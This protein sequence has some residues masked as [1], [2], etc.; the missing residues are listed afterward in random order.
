MLWKPLFALS[1]L[2]AASAVLAA[3]EPA[4]AAK[5]EKP[6]ARRT[7][8]VRVPSRGQPNSLGTPLQDAKYWKDALVPI[9]DEPGLPR[10]LLIGDSV[11]VCYTLA[12]RELLKGEANVHRIPANGGT[13]TKSLQ[14]IDGWLGEGHWD[15]IHFNWGLHDLRQLAGTTLEQYEQ[16]LRKLVKRLQATSAKLI[17]CSSTPLPGDVPRSAQQ[18]DDLLARNAVA[19]KI[20][21][22]NGIAIEDLF[23]FAKPRLAKIQMPRSAH[24]TEEGSKVLAEPIARSIRQAIRSPNR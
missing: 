12:T 10:V 6:A 17:W 1:W 7:N 3:D 4:Q 24:F 21:D 23:T 14:E 11:S 16:N 8:R 22:E 5:D 15:V 9:K 18:T 2:L 20:M 19:K 13:T